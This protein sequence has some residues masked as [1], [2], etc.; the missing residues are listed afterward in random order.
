LAR[1]TTQAAPDRLTRG[2]RSVSPRR[3]LAALAV[4]L[5]LAVVALRVWL[6]LVGPL[7]GDRDLRERLQPWLIPEPLR[8]G[9]DFLATLAF[10]VVA[11]AS[12][13]AAAWIIDGTRGRR[14]ALGVPLAASAVVVNSL[15]K[16]AWGPTPLHEE[17]YG[18]PRNFP[19][20]HVT[21]ATAL[22]GYLAYLAY[23][24]RHV[25]PAI[26]AAAVAVFM[27]PARMM[28][29]THLLSD[30]IAGY[31]LGGAWLIGVVLWVTRRPA[32]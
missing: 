13:A 1:V 12:V 21:Y 17:L 27:G 7:P 5:G 24:R 8:Q 19:S 6:E 31:L 32:R 25:R 18:P 2:L 4:A 14:R 10:P 22:F 30:V 28:G 9:A 11:V 3:L 23:E 20:G 29:S 15:L 26:L 16:L